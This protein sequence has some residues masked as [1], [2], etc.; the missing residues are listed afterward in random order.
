MRS[1]KQFRCECGGVVRPPLP[2]HCPHCGCKIVGVRRRANWVGPLCVGL[3]FA[4]LAVLLFW[5][6]GSF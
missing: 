6:A 3:L 4:A 2:T 5:L 1:P